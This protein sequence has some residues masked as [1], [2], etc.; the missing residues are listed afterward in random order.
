M[1][2]IKDVAKLA[3]VSA[4]TAS[5][6]LHDSPMI[7]SATKE[8]VRKAMTEL[9]YSPNFSAQNLVKQRS[10]TVA[11]VLPVREIP[12][13]L[14]N[15]PFFM[16]IIQGI[17]GVCSRERFM[18]SLATGQTQEEL[19]SSVRVLMQSGR[20]DKFIFLYAK[21]EDGVYQLVRANAE[22]KCVIV[23]Y[24]P[25]KS[26]PQTFFVDTDNHQAG[27]DAVTF[28]LKKGY[29]MPVYVCTDLSEMV[30]ESRFKGYEM[31]MSANGRVPLCLRLPHGE[32]SFNTEH[33]KAFLQTNQ[34]IDAFVCCD[35]MTAIYLLRLLKA[36]QVP[37]LFG[38]ISFNNSLLAELESPSL[39][40]VDIFPYDLGEAAAELLFE[41]K[42]HHALKKVI[43]PHSIVERQSTQIDD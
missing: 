3:G 11:I 8:R 14:G 31:T 35:D 41:Q 1:V 38:I 6:V 5:R 22:S 18:V 17:T 40:S 27:R 26:H 12:Q 25:T 28:L 29:Q 24:D 36:L 43:I 37:S 34:G 32:V 4:S 42:E 16:Q 20:V 13:H 9:N 21:E 19:L 30:Q 2:T 33:L 7:S 23:G 15:N 39:T 10:N